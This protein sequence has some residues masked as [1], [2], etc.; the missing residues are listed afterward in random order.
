MTYIKLLKELSEAAADWEYIGMMLNLNQESLNII[1]GDH[2]NQCKICFMEMIKLWF[3]Q[4][5]PRPS[6]SALVE[7]LDVLGYQLL[8]K[9]LKDKFCTRTGN[10]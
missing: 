6:W 8:A 10:T 5:N 7:P 1:K 4:V 9:N 2:P 3:K